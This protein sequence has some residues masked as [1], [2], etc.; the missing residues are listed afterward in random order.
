M[1]WI[2]GQSIVTILLNCYLLTAEY[3][4][5][6]DNDEINGHP[7]KLTKI[8]YITKQ[9]ATPSHVDLKSIDLKGLHNVQYKLGLKLL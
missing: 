1:S 7:L 4:I 5:K 2:L 9:T 8:S 6:N 3:T